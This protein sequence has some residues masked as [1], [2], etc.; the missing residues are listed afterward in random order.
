M[1]KNIVK[2]IL[3]ATDARKKSLVFVDEM[4]WVYSLQEAIKSAKDGL[5]KNVYIGPQ[6]NI[7][8]LQIVNEFYKLAQDW[9]K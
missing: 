4:L 9:L 3:I 1:N 7:R 8:G 5:F 6:A 2:I